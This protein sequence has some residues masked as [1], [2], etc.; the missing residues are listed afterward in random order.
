MDHRRQCFPK[1]GKHLVG[2]ARLYCGMLGKKHNCP[3]TADF[4]VVDADEDHAPMD[5]T[6]RARIP[7]SHPEEARLASR[8][9]IEP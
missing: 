1:K 4:R 8:H 9:L 6:S 5:W 2:V 7:G 3:S